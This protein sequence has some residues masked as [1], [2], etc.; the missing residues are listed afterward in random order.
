MAIW[1]F[2]L[3]FL[4]EKV[5]LGKYDVLPLAIP[6]DLAEDFSWWSEIQPP[7]GFEEQ[8]SLILPAIA[9][10]STSQRMWGQKDRDDA[11]VLYV[12]ESKSKVE[13]IA[14]RID[15]S[16]ISSEIVH[17]ICILARQLGCVL[18]TAEHEILAPDESMVL[19]AIH[20]STAKKYI[21]DPVATLRSLG[22]PEVQERLNKP[23][24]DK[25][26]EPPRETDFKR[27][28]NLRVVVE[29]GLIILAAIMM[30]AYYRFGI[31]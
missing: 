27:K 31:R 12:D 20:H 10:S 16:A 14:F 18:M 11:H 28:S 9:S 4:P 19:A 3:I 21:D 1:Q 30:W 2:R 29:W 24:R 26:A 6:Q 25:R 15:A 17:R 8:I 13:E 23:L 5:L 7:A 22:Q